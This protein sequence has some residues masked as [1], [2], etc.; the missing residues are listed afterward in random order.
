MMVGKILIIA[1]VNFFILLASERTPPTSFLH[2][3]PI[4]TF[5]FSISSQFEFRRPQKSYGEFDVTFFG[6]II[7][8]ILIKIAFFHLSNFQLIFGTEN[9][10]CSPYPIG[11][12]LNHR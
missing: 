4:L 3:P 5:L 7:Q 11:E 10:R 12:V 8:I 2:Y 6:R 1:N 9:R